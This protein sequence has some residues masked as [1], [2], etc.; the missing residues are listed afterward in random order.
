MS[1][2]SP[3]PPVELRELPVCFAAA[4]S[5]D[6]ADVAAATGLAAEAI[7]ALLAAAPLVVERIGFLPGFPY[8]TGVPDV[9]HLPRRATPRPRVPAGSVALA[10]GRLGVYPVESPG[11]WHLIGRTPLRLFDA[12]RASP[13]YF[14]AGASVRVRSITRAEF[15]A[16]AAAESA[17]ADAERVAAATVA[18]DDGDVLAILVAGPSTTVE[19]LGRTGWTHVGV[20]PGGVSDPAAMRLANALVGNPADAAVLEFAMQGP[21]LVPSRD[22]TIA[23][24]GG[25]CDASVDGARIR[26]GRAERV[27]AGSRLTLGPVHR[28]LRAWLAV[29]GGIAVPRV[30]GSRSTHRLGGFGGLDGRALRKGDRLPLGS[31]S[32]RSPSRKRFLDPHLLDLPPLGG[33]LVLRY[34]PAL[35][36]PA[37]ARPATHDAHSAAVFDDA[38]HVAIADH[39][40]RVHPDSDRMGLR[41]DG[42]PLPRSVDAPDPARAPSIPVTFGTIQLPP[43]GRPIILGADHQTTGGYPV[44][45]TLLEADRS[46]FAQCRP[47]D[48]LRLVPV[49]AAA[50]DAADAAHRR[51]LTTASA[52][53]RF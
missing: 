29:D 37:V 53:L 19:D 21:T 17:R 3:P 45:G 41:L 16:F 40:W 20:A 6:L 2:A 36:D 18:A 48:T 32:G 24:T 23:I 30:L 42:P 44:I 4:F 31:P 28:G 52:A 43:D 51:D 47:G 26:G 13:S 22:V 38:P 12:W 9:L 46:R 27:A 34:R 39:L 25:D 7:P 11:G 15:D 35:H 14:V 5:A 8:I 50:A 1:A 49:S 33:T 10:N